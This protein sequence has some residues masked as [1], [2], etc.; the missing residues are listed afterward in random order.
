MNT[1]ELSLYNRHDRSMVTASDKKS[2]ILTNNGSKTW[3][4]A[5]PTAIITGCDTKLTL[6]LQPHTKNPMAKLFFTLFSISVSIILLAGSA[7][8]ETKKITI[9]PFTINS[10]KDISYIRDGLFQMLSSRL[11]RKGHIIVADK[12]EFVP[13]LKDSHNLLDSSRA[14]K[15][16]KTTNSDYLLLGSITEFAGAFSLDTKIY[17]VKEKN[18]NTFYAQA[19]NLEEIIPA[20]SSLAAEINKKIFNRTTK[21][22]K[23]V[24]TEKIKA[25]KD[26]IISNPEKLMHQQ[27]GK[28][29]Q[30]K[31]PFWKFW[32][33]D[34]PYEEN[35]EEEEEK[36]FWKFW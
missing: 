26:K 20:A 4:K 7:K 22:L 11:S 29:D 32:G 19:E 5:Q 10:Q 36:P 21:A 13:L 6:H 28:Q 27:F 2:K 25:V 16:A 17:N 33:D 8:A 14:D 18:F 12:N 1:A 15:I 9:C 31:K 24:E 3:S 35:E 34:D 30:V 23:K